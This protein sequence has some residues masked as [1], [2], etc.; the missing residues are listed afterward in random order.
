MDHQPKAL[1]TTPENE[2]RNKVLNTARSGDHMEAAILLGERADLFPSELVTWAIEY[3][4]EET[5][6]SYFTALRNAVDQEPAN[7]L[8]ITNMIP[9]DEKVG[10]QCFVDG[11]VY[12]F[13]GYEWRS[14]RFTPWENDNE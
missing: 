3:M 9:A 13:N 12:A 8:G 10:E 4:S 7:T 5:R 6:D 2:Y 14:K 11:E 1:K